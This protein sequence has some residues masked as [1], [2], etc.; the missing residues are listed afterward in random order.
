MK[1]RP[2]SAA[3]RAVRRRP[4]SP[5]RCVARLLP[6]LLILLATAARALEEFPYDLRL[7][8]TLMDIQMLDYAERQLNQMLARYP[9]KKEELLI[10][11]ARFFFLTGKLAQAEAALKAIPA[12]SPNAERAQ[13]LTAEMAFRRSDFATAEKIY[14]AYFAR[15]PTP[16]SQAAE[17]VKEFRDLVA[18]YSTALREQ[19]N[20]AGAAKAMELLKGLQGEDAT[21]DSELSFLKG[22]TVLTAA[23]QSLAQGKPLDQEAVKGAIKALEQIQWSGGLSPLTGLALVEAGRGYVLLK[24]YDKAVQSIKSVTEILLQTEEALKRD[25][26]LQASPVA[27]AQLYYGQAQVGQALALKAKDAAAGEALMLEALKRFRL[28]QRNYAKSPYAAQASIEFARARALLEKEFGKKL[29]DESGAEDATVALKLQEAEPWLKAKKYSEAL[30]LCLQAVRLGRRSDRLPEAA[31]KLL[32]C[33]T[34][35]GRFLEAQAV[36][37]H[38]ADTYPRD[39]STALALLR[40]G[41]EMQQKAKEVKTEAEKDRL[42]AESMEAWDLFVQVA[43]THPKAADVAFAIAE[44]DYA[45]ALAVAK[46]TAGMADGAAKEKVK[47]EARALFLAAVPHYRRMIDLFPSWD[48]GV[49]AYYKLG[50]IYQSAD[51]PADAIVNFL[52]YVDEEKSPDR[53]RDRLEAKFLAADLMVR[54]GRAAEAVTQLTELLEW[55]APGKTEGVDAATLR[56]MQEDAASSL[57]WA[58]DRAAE[59]SRPELVALE[60]QTA[61]ARQEKAAAEAQLKQAEEQAAAAAAEVRK[62]DADLQEHEKS[63][64]GP[65]TATTGTAAEAP[66]TGAEKA[67]DDQQKAE[68]D[69]RIQAEMIKREKDR[70]AGEKLDLVQQRDSLQEARKNVAERLK[71]LGERSAAVN[72]LLATL[73]KEEQPRLAALEAALSRL[74]AAETAH[75]ASDGAVQKWQAALEEAKQQERDAKDPAALKAASAAREQAAVE[76]AKAEAQFK[77]TVA[78][79]K[80]VTTPEVEAERKRLQAAA[81]SARG[82]VVEQEKLLDQLAHELKRAEAEAAVEDATLRAL[83]TSLARNE[84]VQKLLL[85]KPY[86]AA[87]ADAQTTAAVQAELE[88]HRARRDARKARAAFLDQEA[89]ERAAAAVE[90]IAAAAARIK[91]L[92]EQQAPVIAHILDLKKQAEAKFAEFLKA[93]P[94]SKYAP[95]NLAA[96]GL[97]KL[98][99]KQ[100]EEAARILNEVATRYPDAR[101]VKTALF[102]L[103]RAQCE[104]QQYDQAAAVFERILKGPGEEATA[105]LNYISDKMLEAARPQLALPA[106]LELLA[107]GENPAHPDAAL[108]ADRLREGLLLRAA[109]ATLAL[110]NPGAALKYL[111]KLFLEKPNTGYFFEAKFLSAQARQ[112]TRP[113][114]LAGAVRDLGEITQYA[115]DA[116]MLNRA[117]CD[118]GDAT[119]AMGGRDN[120]R[121][122]VAR[123]Q[124][125]VEL[126]DPADAALRPL[127]ERAVFRSAQLFA[128]LGETELR[129]RMVK[130]Y[131]TLFPKGEHSTEITRLPAAEFAPAPPAG[132]TQP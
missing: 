87:M 48:K 88:A 73:R 119:D 82:K 113:P 52:A 77:V 53:L 74:K 54:S 105:N 6:L 114:D 121:M 90:A 1:T 59:E 8:R 36:A 14:A 39:E 76:I 16:K 115:T 27:P 80:K 124:Q 78:A 15:H 40:L 72:Q 84:L 34:A 30:P 61:A 104:I 91:G 120:V 20:P 28:V 47:E 123:F 63:L 26:K 4:L 81:D 32:E 18:L 100:Y 118:V 10:E 5:R 25:G 56:R 22:Q 66:K 13:L 64:A 9:D 70:L 11:Q 45:R 44:N 65:Q 98:E 89:K 107:R 50:W 17:D 3:R 29:V 55:L 12:A 31:G 2:Q 24:Q 103:G 57:A 86:A 116:V 97:I 108:I 110:D 106:T 125:V 93:Y 132:A 94:Q 85:D 96:L 69:Q 71:G 23:E 95:D 130:R 19:G 117:L 128:R 112:K 83:A 37:S 51:Q 101:A 7:V 41:W 42:T 60:E 67:V 43:P 131:Q 122:A 46:T 126:T 129:D 79:L 102:S 92:E 62:A 35:L 99:F 75:A 111:D 33:Y 127:L 38:L 68:L 21:S 109:K 49:R 58:Y